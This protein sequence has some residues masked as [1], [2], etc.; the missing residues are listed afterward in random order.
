MTTAENRL[1]TPDFLLICVALA[2]FF[3]SYHLLTPAFPRYLDTLS[4]PPWAGAATVVASYIFTSMLVR[5]LVGKWIDETSC[6]PWMLAGAAIFILCPFLYPLMGSGPPLLLVRGLHGAGLALFY[7]AAHALVSRLI[8]SSRRA[9]GMGA[10]GNAVKIAMAFSPGLA[11]M[12]SDQNAFGTLFGLASAFAVLALI[13]TFLIREKKPDL[14]TTSP[15]SKGA[16]LNR[17]AI[18]PGLVQ[19][20]TSV[21]FGALMSFAPMLALEHHLGMIQGWGWQ[22]PAASVFYTAYAIFLMGSRALTG[23]WSDRFGRWVTVIPGVAGVSVSM[24]VLAL[25]RDPWLFIAGGAL[26]G[27]AAGMVMPSLMAIVTD[28]V[29]VERRGSAM[30]TFTLM[31]DGGNLLGTYL[32]GQLGPVLGFGWTFAGPL[33]LLT[34]AALGVFLW[35]ERRSSFKRPDNFPKGLASAAKAATAVTR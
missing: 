14:S 32:A 24:L 11:V 19:G 15:G 16:W 3:I 7:T 4:S 12:L 25:A 18:G 5:P 2:A 31:N 30:A 27:L 9:E 28:R 34:L 33:S 29:P 21:A 20:L 8:P 17:E 13:C 22:A 35:L 26:Y 23:P 6:K 1:Y 10:S